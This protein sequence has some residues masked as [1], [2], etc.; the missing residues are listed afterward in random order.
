LGLAA[1]GCGLSSSDVEL[2]GGVFDALGISAAM[3]KKEAEPKLAPRAGLVLPP[4]EKKLPKPGEPDGAAS[5]VGEAWP[6][7][8]DQRKLRTADQLDRQQAEF[9]R[10]QAL[11]AKGRSDTV[12]L[13]DGPKGPCNASVL[14]LFGQSGQQK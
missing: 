12:L 13:P 6:D 3:S 2:N 5:V 14:G 4:D 8:P 11:E 10:K 7:D 9:C 1:G